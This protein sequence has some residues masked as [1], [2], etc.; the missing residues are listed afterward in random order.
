MLHDR[1]CRRGQQPGPLD[2]ERCER[3]RYLSELIGHVKREPRPNSPVH[4]R[5]LW[6]D[7][8]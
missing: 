7:I 6:K 3:C 5:T 4:H 2:L 8:A 1:Q